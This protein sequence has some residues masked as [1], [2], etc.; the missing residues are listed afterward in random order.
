[1]VL[2]AGPK[3]AVNILPEEV[4]RIYLE[5]LLVVITTKDKDR[6]PIHFDFKTEKEASDF[7]KDAVER[8]KS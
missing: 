1:M 4:D 7:Y 8:L 3:Y 6:L 2:M 5:Y